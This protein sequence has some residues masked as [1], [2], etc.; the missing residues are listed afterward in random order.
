MIRIMIIS[1]M[2]CVFGPMSVTAFSG[3][4]GIP[5]DFM[6][7]RETMFPEALSSELGSVQEFP[8]QDFRFFA[9]RESSGPP[10]QSHSGRASGSPPGTRAGSSRDSSRPADLSEGESP[11][12][13]IDDAK[14]AA[15]PSKGHTKK[16]HD[17][18]KGGGRSLSGFDRRGGPR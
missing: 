11:R 9:Q 15:R 16:K 10:G 18:T 17:P 8:T 13:A 14:N 5:P 6:N 1:A 7:S 4:Q 12:N 2:M 3:V